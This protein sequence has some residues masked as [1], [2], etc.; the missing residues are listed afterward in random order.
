MFKSKL[1]MYC[2]MRAFICF[3]EKS[4][5]I[6]LCMCEWELCEMGD[7][8][9]LSIWEPAVPPRLWQ[10]ARPPLLSTL[11]TSSLTL[12]LS[13]ENNYYQIIFR[14]VLQSVRKDLFFL[15]DEIGHMYLGYLGVIS[16]FVHS[17]GALEMNGWLEMSPWMAV[18]QG[19]ALVQ[20]TP[21]NH[22]Y[23]ILLSCL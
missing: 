7:G 5:H 3:V 23:C 19:S 21:P 17:L 2:E 20:L 8:S 1:N 11:P 4:V 16:F 6:F 10:P 9:H 12:V 13:K 22:G 15:S 18:C 14:Q